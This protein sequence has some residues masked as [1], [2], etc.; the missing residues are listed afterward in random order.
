MTGGLAIYLGV[1]RILAGAA[2]GTWNWFL[3]GGNLTLLRVGEAVL[4]DYG[5]TAV[6][7]AVITTTA[8]CGVARQ[9]AGSVTGP[10]TTTVR[11]AVRTTVNTLTI[12]SR[13]GRPSR[14]MFLSQIIGDRGEFS[15]M[16]AGNIKKNDMLRIGAALTREH[17]TTFV[18]NS[19]LAR[20]KRTNFFSKTTNEIHFQGGIDKQHRGLF[21]EEVQ[22]AFDHHCG[23]YSGELTN[24]QLHAITAQNII[25]NP[26]LPTTPEDNVNLA[27]YVLENGK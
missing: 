14:A 15:K 1:P 12:A 11:S 27:R 2:Y 6:S 9:T 21:Y 26:L 18:Y 3:A 16:I 13:G 10:I 8:A 7:G 5:G 24:E 19:P 17:G 22:H 20:A 23:R 4:E 25:D